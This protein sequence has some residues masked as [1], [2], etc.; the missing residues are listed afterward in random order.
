MINASHL[1]VKSTK[2]FNKETILNG[3]TMDA[4]CWRDYRL[5]C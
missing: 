3:N 2:S 1:G 5:A 4:N